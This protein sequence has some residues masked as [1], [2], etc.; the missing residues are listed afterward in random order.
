MGNLPTQVA[1]KPLRR[2]ARHSNGSKQ[3][4]G[5][6]IFEAHAS[7]LDRGAH[8]RERDQAGFYAHLKTM[9][10]KGRKDVIHNKF[11]ERKGTYCETQG[12][13]ARGG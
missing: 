2:L 8:A 12:L 6:K 9:G 11:G 4:C 7:K 10:V 13:S 5:E 3:K 1:G